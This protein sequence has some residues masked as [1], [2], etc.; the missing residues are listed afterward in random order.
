MRDLG[1]GQPEEVVRFVGLHEV[2]VPRVRNDP[3]LAT[4]LLGRI[5]LRTGTREGSTMSDWTASQLTVL[6][7]S[8]MSD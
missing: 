1:H 7:F 2:V 8:V 4:T 6:H 5:L 3:I